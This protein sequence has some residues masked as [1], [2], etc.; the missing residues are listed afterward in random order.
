MVLF[1]GRMLLVTLD[2]KWLKI[3]WE[4][5]TIGLLPFEKVW[6]IPTFLFVCSYFLWMNLGSALC[7]TLWL[8]NKINSDSYILQC[9]YLSYNNY[10]DFITNIKYFKRT[11]NLHPPRWLSNVAVVEQGKSRDRVVASESDQKFEFFRDF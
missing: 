2:R 11:A 10:D 3:C 5:P 9:L 6:G 7:T 4:C 1:G 8:K